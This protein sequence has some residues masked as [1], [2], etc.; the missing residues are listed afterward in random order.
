MFLARGLR[1][2]ESLTAMPLAASTTR[3][4]M[5]SSPEADVVAQSDDL[6]LDSPRAP[7][8]ISVLTRRS[9]R[10]ADATGTGR[11]SRSPTCRCRSPHPTIGNARG[12]PP[13]ARLAARPDR[14]LVP[15]TP[16]AARRARV[17]PS[18]DSQ[19]VRVGAGRGVVDRHRRLPGGDGVGD[20]RPVGVTAAVGGL[21]NQGWR[22]IPTVRVIDLSHIV[23]PRTPTSSP[24]RC[25]GRPTARPSSRG[26]RLAAGARRALEGD[27]VDRLIPAGLVERGSDGRA[28]Q[29]PL[30]RAVRTSAA[31]RFCVLR[32]DE[33]PV[34]GD[35]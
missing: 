22:P 8:S 7:A 21:M 1:A 29:A 4:A 27:R 17:T 13:L 19:V 11:R 5:T 15:S 33:R 2:G 30:A 12:L 18:V 32:T 23:H 31:P 3:K 20:L 34:A 26:T 10:F 16:R 35:L 25:S 6:E 14:T 9:W 24:G 28:A